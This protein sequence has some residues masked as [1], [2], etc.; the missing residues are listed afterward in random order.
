[1]EQIE[2]GK[3]TQDRSINHRSQRHFFISKQVGFNPLEAGRSLYPY[4]FL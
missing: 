1:M 4:P 3:G 2:S